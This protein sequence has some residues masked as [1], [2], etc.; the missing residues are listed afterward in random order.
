[1]GETV[2]QDSYNYTTYFT[3]LRDTQN[4]WPPN[5]KKAIISSDIQPSVF[6]RSCINSA[7]S[8][9]NMLVPCQDS[10]KCPC[11]CHPS[12]FTNRVNIEIRMIMQVYCSNTSNAQLHM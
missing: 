1:M 8:F 11:S 3:L 7:L 2:Q 6:I 12:Q 10:Q 9:R 4:E 5:S